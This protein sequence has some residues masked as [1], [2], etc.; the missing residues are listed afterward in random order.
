M[1]F[2]EL[3]QCNVENGKRTVIE[4][5]RRDTRRGCFA[6]DDDDEEGVEVEIG[7][8]SEAE[9]AARESGKR[10]RKRRSRR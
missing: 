6:G 3:M 7:V 9:S 4:G 2:D 5:K 8:K 10:G 1:N